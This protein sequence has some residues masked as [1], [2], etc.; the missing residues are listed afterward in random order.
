MWLGDP[1]F[2]LGKCLFFALSTTPERRKKGHHVGVIFPLF[3]WTVLVM[4]FLL[5]LDCSSG[6]HTITADACLGWVGRLVFWAQLIAQSIS[7]YF[8]CRRRPLGFVCL[9]LSKQSL[10]LWAWSGMVEKKRTSIFS[11]PSP[12]LTWCVVWVSMLFRK[13][14]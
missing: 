10:K 14:M 7:P 6:S 13:N 11:P 1:W 3:F 5:F 2:S 9:R 8:S 12:D 4:V